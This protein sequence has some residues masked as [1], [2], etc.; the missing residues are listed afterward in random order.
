MVSMW[1]GICVLM[2]MIINYNVHIPKSV[3]KYWPNNIINFCYGCKIKLKQE[4]F[5]MFSYIH[6][7]SVTYYILCLY[8]LTLSYIATKSILYTEKYSFLYIYLSVASSVH[9]FNV[10]QKSYRSLKS[11]HY[12]EPPL[13]CF[14]P[15]C[16]VG[17][18]A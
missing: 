10:M 14:A 1:L 15:H 13:E 5:L 4:L 9:L 2:K 17:Y 6:T 7:M 8:T 3:L 12:K 11:C 18:L 16:N